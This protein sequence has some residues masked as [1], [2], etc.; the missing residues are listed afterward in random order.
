MS[1]SPTDE[2][3]VQKTIRL[4]KFLETEVEAEMRQRGGIDWPA[5]V[6]LAL[7]NEVRRER[8]IRVMESQAVYGPPPL[9]RTPDPI[10][11]AEQ[12][13]DDNQRRRQARKRQAG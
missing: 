8:L 9:R 10:T 5:F 6:K 2:A 12:I 11:A 1:E 7:A 13:A 4:P 3:L